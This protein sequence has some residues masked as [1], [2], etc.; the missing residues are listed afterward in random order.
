MKKK[1]SIECCAS[2]HR[3]HPQVEIYDAKKQIEWGGAIFRFYF[4]CPDS[5]E[6]VY[7]VEDFDV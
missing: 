7:I 3:A 4:V 2:C 6:R 1:I 5:G